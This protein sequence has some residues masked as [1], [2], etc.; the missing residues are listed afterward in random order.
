MSSEHS[1]SSSDEGEE[2]VNHFVPE[3]LNWSIEDVSRW[4]KAIGLPQY[5]ACL[6][7]NFING[8]KMI[9]L[10]ASNLPQMNIHDFQHILHIT[11]AARRVL[12]VE[13][14]YWNVS[15]ADAMTRPLTSF[16][17]QKS[18]TG[19]RIDALTYK[20]FHRNGFDSLIAEEE[21]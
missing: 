19:V 4:V 12:C 10:T 11:K 17:Q 13:R 2:K 15:V 20:E 7:E 5:Q 14:P 18:R 16:L 6:A 21:L 8:R 3:C 1:G 9:L